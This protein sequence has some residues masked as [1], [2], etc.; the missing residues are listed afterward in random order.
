M[1]YTKLPPAVRAWLYF[2]FT[3]A[4]AAYAVW[5]ATDGDWKQV[6]AAGISAAIGELA[7]ANVTAKPDKDANVHPVG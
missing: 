4:A 1:P 7:R 3:I 2:L 5:Q 6:V